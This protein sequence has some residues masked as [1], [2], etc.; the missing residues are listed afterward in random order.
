GPVKGEGS[1]GTDDR[2]ETPPLLTKEQIK[3]H[4]SALKSLIKSHNRKNKGDPIP[5][6]F[7]MEDIKVQDHN[8]AKGK[9]VVD[10]DLRKPFKEAQRTPLTHRIIEFAGPKYK[11]PS[12][13]KLYDGTTDLKDH[14]SRFASAANSGEWPMPVWC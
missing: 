7:E 14:L 11:M 2:E 6:D 8:I 4:V 1:E 9:E 3:G 10:K 12:N 5:L 13:I